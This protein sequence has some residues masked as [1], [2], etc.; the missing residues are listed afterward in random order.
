M[1]FVR[2]GKS[3]SIAS[4]VQDRLGMGMGI[5]MDMGMGIGIGYLFV[6]YLDIFR[7]ALSHV[8]NLKILEDRCFARMGGI[9]DEVVGGSY[10]IMCIIILD[11][12]EE[13]AGECDRWG[14]PGHTGASE[15]SQGKP[16]ADALGRKEKGGKRGKGGKTG[17]EGRQGCGSGGVGERRD[18]RAAGGERCGGSG[19]GGLWR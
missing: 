6:P 15:V 11:E 4:V 5:G 7:T 13:R 3:I 17:G 9:L 19:E 16:C 18:G 2:I 1:G 12:R 14:Q 10:D 8:L